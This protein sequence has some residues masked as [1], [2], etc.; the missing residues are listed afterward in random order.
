MSFRVGHHGDASS[1]RF[2][3]RRETGRATDSNGGG[4]ACVV[5]VICTDSWHFCAL[6]RARVRACSC[7]QRAV[8][9]AE[10]FSVLLLPR[11]HSLLLPVLS[12]SPL[13]IKRH[14]PWKTQKN[15]EGF[16]ENDGGG[17]KAE[18]I[19]GNCKEGG[20]V[21]GGSSPVAPQ[22]VVGQPTRAGPEGTR[23]PRRLGCGTLHFRFEG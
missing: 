9:G 18:A 8:L 23:C 4:S 15:M 12:P 22:Q 19:L 3:V 21:G 5:T 1:M 10:D 17:F 11:P 16:Q 6:V 14:S 7:V 2:C 13:L 20:I